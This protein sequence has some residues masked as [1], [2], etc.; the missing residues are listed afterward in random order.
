MKIFNTKEKNK[1]LD[2]VLNNML[3]SLSL[4]HNFLDIVI[5]GNNF[6]LPIKLLDKFEDLGSK[7]NIDHEKI[8]SRFR[9]RYHD[10][11]TPQTFSS[12]KKN[13]Q[14]GE[15]RSYLTSIYMDLEKETIT[16]RG[17]LKA[18]E[19]LSAARKKASEY[20]LEIDFKENETYK[21]ID[22]LLKYSRSEINHPD[23]E[24]K[25]IKEANVRSG[26]HNLLESMN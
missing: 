8:Y 20:S 6:Y 2:E 22:K 17:I 23:F 25:E 1:S 10:N 16:P 12:F 14:E 24:K 21:L 4:I 26:L 11:S 5:Q 15:I 7:H 13:I 3:E 18:Q 9:L 19:V